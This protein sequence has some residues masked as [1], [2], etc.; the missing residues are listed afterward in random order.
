MAVALLS[1][2]PPAGATIHVKANRADTTLFWSLPTA[3]GT[4]RLL[5]QLTD[6]VRISSRFDF[7]VDRSHLYFTLTDRQSDLWVVDLKKR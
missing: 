7:A 3:G 6:P 1:A 2:V 5:A 4:P